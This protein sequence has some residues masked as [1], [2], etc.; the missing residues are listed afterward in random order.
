MFETTR[1]PPELLTETFKHIENDYKTLYSCIL[2]NKQWHNINIPTLWRNPLYS[3]NS[4]KILI[5]C[6]LKEDK[7]SLTSIELT[8]KLLKKPP[9][10]NYARFCTIIY[11]SYGLR[12]L[13]K[14]PLQN[15]LINF[16]LEHSVGIRMLSTSNLDCNFLINHR[17]FDD[18]F[19]SL[20]A[21]HWSSPY[22][23]EFF[24]K[25][26]N[27]C[28]NIQSLRIC[29]AAKY[30]KDLYE[31]AQL[32]KTQNQIKYLDIGSE[33]NTI[34]PGELKKAILTHS[35]SIIFYGSC[36]KGN[37]LDDLLLSTFKNLKTLELRSYAGKIKSW[38][39][40]SLPNIES[41]EMHNINQPFLSDLSGFI[42][43]NGKIWMLKII[44]IMIL[45]IAN[46]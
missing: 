5:N 12:N 8:F 30:D 9:S 18:C 11:I 3:L 34:L 19:Q 17:R 42:N 27:I 20:Y 45:E 33:R 7:D 41:V 31:L 1:L 43:I 14:I 32:I 44:N 26:T 23:G 22:N 15:K 28:K 24:D 25:L 36:C 2:V 40:I 6:L 13:I 21:I 46:L 37:N 39:N 16:I 38:K 29:Y 10:Y 35:Q 4:I